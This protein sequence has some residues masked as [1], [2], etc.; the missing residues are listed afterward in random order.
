MHPSN[1]ARQSRWTLREILHGP[2]ISTTAVLVS[3]VLLQGPNP[4]R[5]STFALQSV[6]VA[7]NIEF[8][9]HKSE[10]GQLHLK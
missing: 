7:L 1:S 4:E 10:L 2:E 8:C 3:Y 9:I 6:I 5:H